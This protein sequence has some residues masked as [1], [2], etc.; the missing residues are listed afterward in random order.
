MADYSL[1]KKIERV[2]FSST[3]TFLDFLPHVAPGIKTIKVPW[4]QFNRTWSHYGQNARI[5]TQI[6]V[7][8][9]LKPKQEY[10]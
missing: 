1:K 3:H 10:P 8:L 2:K 4:I 6:G 5:S 9:E 7:F